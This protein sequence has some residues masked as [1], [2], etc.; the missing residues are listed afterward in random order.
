MN[1]IMLLKDFLAA[2]WCIILIVFVVLVLILYYHFTKVCIGFLLI[3]ILALSLAPF[4]FLYYYPEQFAELMKESVDEEIV[5]NNIS[6][7]DGKNII[8]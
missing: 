7:N 5:Q 3:C 2:H 4:S 1:E 6:Q 8:S